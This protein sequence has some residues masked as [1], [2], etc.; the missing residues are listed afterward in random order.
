MRDR[1][2]YLA[3]LTVLLSLSSVVVCA[4][5]RSE[6]V[7]AETNFDNFRSVQG[8]AIG[9][10]GTS[11]LAYGGDNLRFAVFNGSDWDLEIIDSTSGSGGYPSVQALQ[12]WDIHIL[13]TRRGRLT[14]AFRSQGATEWEIRVLG[15][16]YP[17]WISSSVDSNG[18]VHAAVFDRQTHTLLYLT[19][20]G[21]DWVQEEVTTIP[22]TGCTCSIALTST[23]QPVISFEEAGE[24]RMSFKEG[25]NWTRQT[26]YHVGYHVLD[27]SLAF[28]SEDLPHIAL[29]QRNL[30]I[31]EDYLRVSHFNGSTW[32]TEDLD[33][34]SYGLSYGILNPYLMIDTYDRYHLVY[35]KYTDAD[36]MYAQDSG[37]GWTF[38]TVEAAYSGFHAAMALDAADDPQVA[39]LVG[40]DMRHYRQNGDSWDMS[41]VDTSHA[42]RVLSS[43]I[44]LNGTDDPHL[45]LQY[46][47]ALYHGYKDNDNWQID[48]VDEP[49][50][51]ACGHYNDIIIDDS[52]TM[53]I[54]YNNNMGGVSPAQYAWFDGSQWQVEYLGSSH[55]YTTLVTALASSDTSFPYFIGYDYDALKFYFYTYDGV[56]WS[57]YLIDETGDV[58]EH[59]A[60]AVDDSG[61]VH[62]SYLEHDD[63]DLR[64]AVG[65]DDSWVIETVDAV[66][67]SGMYN[68]IALDTTGVPYISYYSAGLKMAQ[69][70]GGT[71]TSELVTDEMRLGETAICIDSSGNPHI[72]ADN[73]YCVWDGSQW[74]VMDY[75]YNRVETTDL[76]LDSEDNPHILYYDAEYDLKYITYDASEPEI[77]SVAPAVMYQ[78]AQY[79]GTII[80]GTGF[81]DATA[82]EF[83]DGV[84]VVSWTVDNDTQIT[85]DVLVYAF[86]PVGYRSVRIQ[87]D[88]GWDICRHCVE[89]GYGPPQIQSIEPA[90]YPLDQ[91]LDVLI[92]GANFSDISSVDFGSGITVNSYD[93][94]SLEEIQGEITIDSGAAQGYRDVSVTSPSGTG[95]CSA[96]FNV[97]DSLAAA[98]IFLIDPVPALVYTGV[99]FNIRVRAVDTLGRTDPTFSE[100]ISLDDTVT[101]L[102]EPSSMDLINGEG[103]VEATLSS[104]AH[105]NQI[106][107]DYYS[108]EGY[109]NS[110]NVLQALADCEY[111][112][113]EN[114][115]YLAD[116]SGHSPSRHIRVTDDGSIWIAH[117][118]DNLW[119]AKKTSDTWTYSL[120]DPEPGVG[121]GCSLALDPMGLPH[122][123]YLAHHYFTDYSVRYASLTDYGWV[124]ETIEDMPCTNTALDMGSDGVPHVCYGSQT[125]Q[126]YAVN[127]GDGWQITSLVSPGGQECSLVVD[128]NNLPH[129]VFPSSS[130]FHYFGY[131]GGTWTHDT[132]SLGDGSSCTIDVD[133][134]NNPHVAAVAW[135]GGSDYAIAYGYWTGSSWTSEHIPDSNHCTGMNLIIDNSNHPLIVSTLHITSTGKA[136]RVFTHDGSTWSYEDLSLDMA[137]AGYMPAAV[138]DATDTLHMH[139]FNRTEWGLEY[140]RWNQSAWER[141]I[142]QRSGEIESQ[143]NIMMDPLDQP[144]V[145]Y[146][147]QTHTFDEWFTTGKFAT[148]MQ[149]EWLV[150]ETDIGSGNGKYYSLHPDGSPVMIYID[151]SDHYELHFRFQSG[152]N[153]IDEVI[154]SSDQTFLNVSM[155]HDSYGNPWV[156][157]RNDGLIR[158]AERTGKGWNIEDIMTLSSSDRGPDMAIGPDGYIRLA[159]E[160]NAVDYSKMYLA[161]QT[162]STWE[163]EV[164][165]DEPVGDMLLAVDSGNY[166]HVTFQKSTGNLVYLTWNGTTWE[167]EVLDDDFAY[168]WTLGS[169]EMDSLDRPNCCYSVDFHMFNDYDVRYA[170]RTSGGWQVYTVD[171]SGSTGPDCSMVLDTSDIPHFAY[172]EHF[173]KDLRY[174]SCGIF[175]PPELDF[176]SPASAY[177]GEFIQNMMLEG[178]GL[179]TVT[180]LDFGDGIT[181]ESF[182]CPTN[183]SIIADIRVNETAL[184]GIRNVRVVSPA[185]T[186]LC[187]GCF[188]VL[189][190]G[191][192]PV[193]DTVDPSE[194]LA[195][196]ALRSV[197][198]G[199]HLSDTQIAA[200]GEG[201]TVTDLVVLAD[202]A[203]EVQL[204]IDDDAMAGYRDVTVVTSHGETSC[205]GCFQVVRDDP[206]PTPTP[207]APTSTPTPVPSWTP[208]PTAGTHP[209]ST[210]TPAS[211]RTST[212]ASTTTPSPTP[213]SGDCTVTGVTIEMPS[214]LFHAGEICNCTAVVCNAESQTLNN[215][216]LFVILDVYGTLFF[217]PSFNQ[218]FDYYLPLYPSFPAGE[219]RVEVLPDFA[220][221][222]NTGTVYG[223]YWY[224]AMTNPAIT[225][226]FGELGLFEFGW[227]SP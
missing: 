199:S 95:L 57:D 190:P 179:Y 39:A 189:E 196:S 122:I 51:N 83:G 76:A 116:P 186:D 114:P 67:F 126:N 14:E 125:G 162:E 92:S 148:Y 13:Y 52:G 65:L 118:E 139:H 155:I 36:V 156:V 183:S 100:T 26:I 191:D 99:P 40:W 142:Y 59:S 53:H 48:L 43:S 86:A 181:V 180:L 132:L 44:T 107:A 173:G 221:P 192:A 133:T 18:D 42:K 226:L 38:Q 110:F 1:L 80:T 109:S 85:A 178:F 63:Y 73:K 103:V 150:E 222:P 94:L 130:G 217:A 117:G 158:M 146:S 163:I 82:I 11:Y 200:F 112:T 69:R 30:N 64:Y 131:L 223:I 194:G 225:D 165:Y 81:T 5:W 54:S 206:T 22:E 210:P 174:S 154:A 124:V 98:S 224:G 137:D 25:G 127:E 104:G 152:P 218:V 207:T 46:G 72:V 3:L 195:G 147:Y 32:I 15:Q 105:D 55:H 2:M 101:G 134:S 219:T 34:D 58:G 119:A 68:A 159:F 201:L 149:G 187:N 185:G 197:I 56:Y 84:R 28:D 184:P 203:V 89:I 47:F 177:P 33:S 20:Q 41:V 10:D 143:V 37:S 6:D 216:P 70:T 50:N 61:T 111:H 167:E 45:A 141:D 7:I 198:Q 27:T 24:L 136:F 227:E 31:H 209:P 172:Q 220:W 145:G 91:T 188:V 128:G 144:V 175:T 66:N 212:P 93:V 96:C 71:W 16:I 75:D 208:T 182:E 49:S 74:T 23:D 77:S 168:G 9:P 8:T 205:A 60:L 115:V 215:Y 87:T 106:Q 4:G 204:D 202:E 169:L 29:T 135:L 211:T 153:W 120:V 88:S 19:N 113:I 157:F 164:I 35:S 108:M 214:H 170:V 17:T 78:E 123:S 176:I 166:P 62:I 138:L 151:Y 102:L 171:V 21:T 193:I 129:M 79:P 12:N 161:T 160:S 213:T 97:E 90:G 140:D 121:W